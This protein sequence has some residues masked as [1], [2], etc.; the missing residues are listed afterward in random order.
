MRGLIAVLRISLAAVLVLVA[1]EASACRV[2]FIRTFDNQTVN[3]AMA[4]RTGKPCSIVLNT[5]AGPMLGAQIV[6]R[7]ANGTASVGAG[8]RVIYL[9]RPGFAGRDAFT[10]ARTG[11]DRHN[12]KVVRTVRVSVIVRP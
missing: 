12:A 3:G 2:P 5:S 6:E 1:S 4:A 11:L 7:P 10:Y 8:N 9:S